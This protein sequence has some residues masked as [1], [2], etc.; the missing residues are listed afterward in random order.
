[1]DIRLLVL[2]LGT[3]SIGTDSFVV[4]G[5]LPDVARSFDIEV[6]AAGQLITVYALAYALIVDFR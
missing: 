2:A 5:I 6:A 3:F 1:M 4:A